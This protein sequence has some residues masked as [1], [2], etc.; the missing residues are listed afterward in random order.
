[1]LKHFF[2][3]TYFLLFFFVTLN[4]QRMPGNTFVNNTARNNIQTEAGI[5]GPTKL[6]DRYYWL[7]EEGCRMV[8]ERLNSMPGASLDSIE[9]NSKW[10]LF[11]YSI[12]ASSV[13]Y[14]KK[15]PANKVYH[16]LRFLEL[17]IR[18]GDFLANESEKGH[19]AHRNW[20][21]YMWLEAYRL[22]ENKLGEE[23]RQRWKRGIIKI[24]SPDVEYS[25]TLA[26]SAWYNTPFLN[27]SSNHYSIYASVIFL[28]G[29]V[30]GIKDWEKTGAKNMHRFATE[31]ISP[32]GFWGE[33]N[34]YL[35]TTGYN[36]LTT[37]S[38]A[39]YWE[40][41][42]D[43]AALKALRS[44]TNFHKYY[45]YPDGTPVEVI[46]DRNRHWGRSP[47][48]HFGFTNFADGRR[49]AQFLAEYLNFQNLNMD[50]LGR[51][52]QDALYYHDGPLHSIPRDISKYSN[53]MSIDAGIRKNSPWVAAYSALMGTQA[54]NNPFFLD[55]QGNLSIFH[56][57]LGLIITGAN[58]KRQPELA[59]FQ[60]KLEGTINHLPIN[61]RLQ[62]ND[63]SDRI[64][65]AFNTFF[66][67][68]YIPEFRNNE[69]NFRFAIHGK[70]TPAE[71]TELH[72]QLC[73]KE[74]E[75]LET[76][77]GKKLILGK[78]RIDLTPAEIGGWIRHHGW[79]LQV[80]STAY[81]AWPVYPHN[82]YANAPETSLDKAVGVI[83]VPL[84]LREDP[85]YFVRINEKII[86]FK[87][88]AE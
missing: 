22:L 80:P 78:E 3:N 7:M 58:S 28:A 53:K 70:G 14:A 11:P 68:L 36:Y 43:P 60:E 30:F 20:D 6:P 84:M 85:K 72:L 8:E 16:N 67:D 52:A 71:E 17:S 46:N 18:I 38:V 64:S 32:D 42:K 87:L 31:E 4:A 25:I 1:M 73:L 62:M 83:T 76:A 35:P 88:I 19:L 9:A 75:V 37:S 51:I 59:T 21:G 2:S 45:T 61:T 33:H 23:R 49:L 10:R 27:T 39:L 13:L 12:M 55:R 57:K 26:S 54:I 69:I 66:S 40:Y 34:H 44:A 48:G 15:H 65:L 81:L 5:N 47:W 41:S 29:K 86:S 82:P 56:E 24:L 74:G 63:T 79:K 50:V 77:A